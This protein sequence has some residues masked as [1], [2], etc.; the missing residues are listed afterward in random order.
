MSSKQ[1]PIKGYLLHIT[2]YDPAWLKNKDHEKPFDLSVGLDVIDAMADAGLNLL[3]LDVKDGVVYRSHPELKRHY[4]R[5]IGILDK[6]RKRAEA[7]GLE[8]A[9]KL[10]F[11]QSQLHQHNHWFRPHNDLFDTREY[12]KKGFEVIDE[13]IERLQPKRFFHIGMDEDHSRSY[14]QYVA[15][16]RTLH[17]GLKKRGLKTMIWNDSACH[18]PAAD[19]HRE[20]SLYAETRIPKDVVQVLWNYWDVEAAAFRRIRRLGFNLWGAPGGDPK[21]VR[22]T[23]KAL[24]QCGATG[25]LLTRWRPCI[26]ANRK[27]LINHITKLAPLLV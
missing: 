15:A 1:L 20:K 16:I 14:A 17:D 3:I 23:V 18:W 13:L 19:I 27:D 26:A 24:K 25:V 4:S 2:H 21:Q 9:V 10:N 22:G 5:P 12:W 8:M 7:R 11:S 6:I